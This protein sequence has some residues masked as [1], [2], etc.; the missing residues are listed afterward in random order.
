MIFEC[1]FSFED[2]CTFDIFIKTIKLNGYPELDVWWI[3]HDV[4]HLLNARRLELLCNKFDWDLM[5]TMNW[6]CRSDKSH[7]LFGAIIN[8]W[9]PARGLELVN[10]ELFGNGESL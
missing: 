5:G 7:G 2:G 3:E 9:T 1:C 10:S 8:R 4:K 6:T